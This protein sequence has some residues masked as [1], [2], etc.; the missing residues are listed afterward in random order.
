[1]VDDIL[2]PV[3]GLDFLHLNFELLF[4]LPVIELEQSVHVFFL[5]RLK[6]LTQVEVALA[7]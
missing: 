3:F 7:Q 2:S 5:R 1:M 4:Y 6:V